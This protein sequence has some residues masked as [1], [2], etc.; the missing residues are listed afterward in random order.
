MFGACELKKA[1]EDIELIVFETPRLVFDVNARRPYP[2]L[3]W[4][5]TVPIC[6]APHWDG[7]YRWLQPA[8]ARSHRHDARPLRAVK[9]PP[10]NTGSHTSQASF[11]GRRPS[12]SGGPHRRCGLQDI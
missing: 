11:D 4:H 9:H 7:R 8:A 10:L 1:A 2:A 12:G 5:S 6:G 3:G